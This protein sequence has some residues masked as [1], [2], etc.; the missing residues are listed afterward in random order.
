MSDLS[1]L[2]NSNRIDA[3][4]LELSEDDLADV[5]REQL[6]A[7]VMAYE[8]FHTAFMKEFFKNAVSDDLLSA[9]AILNAKLLEIEFE[10]NPNA[11]D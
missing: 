7:M 2:F 6:I 4:I 3:G 10:H 9:A 11:L 5:T 8:G 1:V